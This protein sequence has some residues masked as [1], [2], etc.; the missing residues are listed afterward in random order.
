MALTRRGAGLLANNIGVAIAN[1][2]DVLEAI[3]SA[4]QKDH[5]RFDKQL[6]EQAVQ[7]AYKHTL[8]VRAMTEGTPEHKIATEALKKKGS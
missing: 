7:A 5:P 8:V 4:L 1:G 6:F 3:M 2:D